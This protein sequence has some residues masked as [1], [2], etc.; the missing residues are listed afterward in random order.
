MYLDYTNKSQ[1]H[2]FYVTV[3]RE[4]SNIC[5]SRNIPRLSF[6][7]YLMIKYEVVTYYNCLMETI[8]TSYCHI[9]CEYNGMIWDGGR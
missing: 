6:S 4:K 7:C 2:L 1:C 8:S 5:T 9:W 3:M